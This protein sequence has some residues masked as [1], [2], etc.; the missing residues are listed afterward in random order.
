MEFMLLFQ[1]VIGNTRVKLCNVLFLCTA[2]VDRIGTIVQYYI[3]YIVLQ[4]STMY[5]IE[6]FQ[7]L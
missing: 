5:K 4:C 6:I 1:W 3:L 2:D 7:N